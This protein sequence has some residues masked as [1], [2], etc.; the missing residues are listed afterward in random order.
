VVSVAS[1]RVSHGDVSDGVSSIQ[2]RRVSIL[3]LAGLLALFAFAGWLAYSGSHWGPTRLALSLSYAAIAL[4]GASLL[5]RALPGATVVIA[6]ED[7]AVRCMLTRRRFHWTEV[8]SVTEIIPFAS[9]GFLRSRRIERWFARYIAPN[10]FFIVEL[11]NRRRVR[12][13]PLIS[14][15]PLGDLR[16][17]VV[18]AWH[19]ACPPRTA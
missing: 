17:E 3:I 1:F 11:H 9:P 8:E 14:A 18:T 12:L 10:E 19:R 4:A 16:R 5:F 2:P 15:M 6:K 13:S 7:C